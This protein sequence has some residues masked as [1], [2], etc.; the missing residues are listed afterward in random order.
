M[1]GLREQQWQ[2]DGEQGNPRRVAVQKTGHK[3]TS[4]DR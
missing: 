2:F 3:P 4:I 1:P